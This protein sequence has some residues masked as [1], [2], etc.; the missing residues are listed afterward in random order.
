MVQYRNIKILKIISPPSKEKTKIKEQILA[1]ML[2]SF[3]SIRPNMSLAPAMTIYLFGFISFISQSTQHLAC[4]SLKIPKPASYKRTNK[5]LK[6]KKEV[7]ACTQNFT[8]TFKVI[9]NKTPY[10][11]WTT[12]RFLCHSKH[13]EESMKYLQLE[14]INKH[15]Q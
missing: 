10:Q 1:R 6:G 5:K 11:I 4:L 7:N 14:S 12:P 8:L 13:F 3:K 9:N 15:Q 2:N